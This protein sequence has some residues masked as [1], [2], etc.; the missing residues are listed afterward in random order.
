MSLR[1]CGHSNAMAG[2]E[3]LS[4]AVGNGARGRKRRGASTRE[5]AGAH[6]GSIR[7]GDEAGEASEAAQGRRRS[8]RPKVEYDD[9]GDVAGRPRMRGSSGMM[10]KTRRSR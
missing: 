5:A 3:K 9:G 4:A 10:K 1:G 7:G 6:S 8:G 2:G